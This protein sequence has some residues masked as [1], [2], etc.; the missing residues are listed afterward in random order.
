MGQMGQ[1]SMYSMSC[2]GW[3]RSDADMPSAYVKRQPLDIKM[4]CSFLSFCGRYDAKR[5]DVI[6]KGI[7]ALVG[8]SRDSS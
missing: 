2:D 1:M 5:I 4:L 6:I 8:D 7:G 3:R